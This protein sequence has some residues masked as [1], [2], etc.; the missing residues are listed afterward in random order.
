MGDEVPTCPHCGVAEASDWCVNCGQDIDRPPRPTGDYA[1]LVE[2]LRVGEPFS[3]ALD[4]ANAIETLQQRLAEVDLP[5]EPPQAVL[6]AA[7]MEL[8]RLYRGEG[9][10]I[11][12]E[13]ANEQTR[14]VYRAIR[15]ALSQKEKG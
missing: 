12:T 1:E 6:D 3:V 14:I 8:S 15:T 9:G 13:A 4:V 5:E 7:Q 11:G 10:W 2:E